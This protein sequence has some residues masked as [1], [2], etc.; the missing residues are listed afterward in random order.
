MKAVLYFTL[1]LAVI[2]AVAAMPARAEP[3]ATRRSKVLFFSKA[4]GF[5]HEA[6]KLVMKDGR[7][8]Y[9]YAVLRELGEK[10]NID[11]TFAKDGSLFTPDYVAEFD[12]FFF[13]TS[14]DLTL[15]RN[16]PVLGDGNPPMTPAGKIALL[17]AIEAGKG[18][19]GVHGATDTFHS[20]G[21]K[22]HG[23][24]RNRDDGAGADPFVKMVGGEF[25]RHD[26]QQVAPVI[27]ADP[28][29]PGMAAVPRNYSP[30]EEWY[31]LKNFAPDL[32]VLLVQ[33]T[34]RMIGPSYARPPFPLAWVRQHGRGRVFYT[35]M[36][37]R[38]DVWTSPVF[39][40]MITGGLEWALRRVEADITPNLKAVAP[41]AGILPVYVAPP[42]PSK[43]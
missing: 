30:M 41:E 19:V 37:H 35:S 6:I 20:P 3:T 23:P 39:Q 26:A 33:D 36:G 21:N 17:R 43:K 29:F 10:N 9:A 24:A 13:Y 25:I 8:G 31:S 4:S 18:F 16:S 42:P 11:F 12:A 34:S 32:H 28:G 5:E 40:A 38:E 22:D 7:P 15:A 14:G 1:L 27:V 2:T